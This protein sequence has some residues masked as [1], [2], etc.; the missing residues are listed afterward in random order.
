MIDDDLT[1]LDMGVDDGTLL[2]QIDRGVALNADRPRHALDSG[3]RQR[4][5]RARNLGVKIDAT[6]LAGRTPIR[7][8]HLGEAGR[9]GMNGPDLQVI[10]R[11]RRQL[12]QCSAGLDAT[13]RDAGCQVERQP[14]RITGDTPL[15]CRLTQPVR[16]NTEPAVRQ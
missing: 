9:V 7:C 16:W 5:R 12:S 3:N 11:R 8:E 15:K 4:G 13:T 6:K 14:L 1:G 2:L 10:G